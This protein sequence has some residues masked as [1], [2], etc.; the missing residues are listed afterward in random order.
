[1]REPS[2]AES[3]DIEPSPSR[4]RSSASLFRR[5]ESKGRA[6]SPSLSPSSAMRGFGS[7][8]SDRFQQTGRR[9][10]SKTRNYSVPTSFSRL[11]RVSNPCPCEGD[12]WP[13]EESSKHVLTPEQGGQAKAEAGRTDCS[14]YD[15]Q[16]PYRP[17]CFIVDVSDFKYSS[18]FIFVFVT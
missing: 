13:W 6:R 2:K 9:R 18:Y 14:K 4:S 5:W 17:Y 8:S 11:P 15:A 16:M 10:R 3:G 1:M 7:A 12:S